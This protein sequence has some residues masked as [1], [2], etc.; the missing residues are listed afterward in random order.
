V[1][2]RLLP[3]QNVAKQCRAT[4]KTHLFCS[5]EKPAAEYVGYSDSQGGKQGGD[6]APDEKRL[7]ERGGASSRYPYLRTTRP[8]GRVNCGG[9]VKRIGGRQARKR[10]KEGK[11]VVRRVT[12]T[13]AQEPGRDEASSYAHP[14][15]RGWW[16][17]AR[18]VAAP[19]H[20]RGVAAAGRLM[21]I[22]RPR[23]KVAVGGT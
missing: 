3:T 18:G 1:T 16:A 14:G 13:T 19:M 17:G 23:P 21:A 11:P 12:T 4:T 15:S 9:S 5:G 10:G 2:C 7:Q 20:L 22:N 6:A 8:S